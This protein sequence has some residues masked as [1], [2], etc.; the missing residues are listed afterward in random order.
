MGGA[1]RYCRAVGTV[2][3]GFGLGFFVAAQIGPISLFRTPHD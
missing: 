2:V 1:A 3:T